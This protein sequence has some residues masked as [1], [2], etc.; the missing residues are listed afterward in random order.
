MFQFQDGAI[1]SQAH[2]SLQIKLSLFQFQDGAI[3]SSLFQNLH[4]VYICVSIP[5][6]CDYKQRKVKTIRLRN[7]VSI[8]RWCDYK[9]VEVSETQ[10]SQLFQFQDGAI[11]SR[12]PTTQR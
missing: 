11:I 2:I 4:D 5:R 12:R 6:W 9:H 3:I 7:I 8:P 10:P 1:I